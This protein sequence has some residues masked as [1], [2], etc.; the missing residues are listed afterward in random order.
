MI[1]SPSAARILAAR[2]QLDAAAALVVK[3]LPLARDTQQHSSILL[4]FLVAAA[5]VAS[6]S[7][8]SARAV[9]HVQEFE[10]SVESLHDALLCITD[11]GR[12]CAAT[13]ELS[14][15]DRLLDTLDPDP[16]RVRY[17][18]TG[19]AILCEARGEST[20]AEL[21]YAEADEAWKGHDCLVEHAH[22]LLGLGRCCL[23]LGRPDD[24]ARS[25]GEAREILMSLG[26]TSLLTQAEELLAEA[27]AVGS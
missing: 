10:Q 15:L 5:I 11:I 1:G 7:G 9:A 27:T 26:A 13:G 4:P 3:L 16:R 12:V 21:L 24:A 6:A 17:T 18:W 20:Q 8:D 19:R 14:R 25:L 2:G 22:A 23:A